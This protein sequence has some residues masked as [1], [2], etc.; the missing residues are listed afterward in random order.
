[1]RKLKPKN[2][3]LLHVYILVTLLTLFA[4]LVVTLLV[5][6]S[7][8]QQAVFD[9]INN[10]HSPAIY[11]SEK[12]SETLQKIA[13]SNHFFQHHN[14]SHPK[15]IFF[16]NSL[17]NP[18][19]SIKSYIKNI[20]DLKIKKQNINIDSTKSRLEKES[21]TLIQVLNELSLA[22]N[23]NLEL[24]PDL[25]KSVK[26]RAQQFSRLHIN[27]NKTLQQKL[28]KLPQE[29]ANKLFKLL[30][31][32]IAV[33]AL[34]IFPLILNIKKT[35]NRM[36][37]AEDHQRHLKDQADKEKSRITALLSA[38][39]IGILFEDNNNNVE[40]INPAFKRMWALSDEKTLIGHSLN[41]LLSNSPNLF[42]NL[43][44][45]S[46]Y[47]LQVLDTHEISERFEVN[48]N[49]GRVLAQLSYPVLDYEKGVIGRLWVYEDITH[50][51]QTAQQLLHLAEHDHLTGLFNRHRFQQDLSSLIDSCSRRNEK[52]A[53]LYFDLD[54]FKFINDTYGHGCGDNVLLRTSSEIN[55]VVRGAELF[56]RL[57][58]DE[59]A[60]LLKLDLVHNID[61]LP[62]RITKTVAS[63][64]FRFQGN[65]LRVTTSVGVAIYPDHGDNSEDLVA[66]ADTAMYQAK[67]M[68]KN[69]WSLYNPDRDN[70]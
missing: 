20:N 35:I 66:H 13:Q 31:V 4:A 8:E 28:A 2:A 36:Y 15:N 10:Y 33:I 25:I 22:Q 42:P 26:F 64:P 57:G 43:D 61:A 27:A 14:E 59:F 9:E 44:H 30:F 45:S 58:G 29:N 50:E 7:R 38:M 5:I 63:I 19:Y 70:S 39:N 55:T 3:I 49:D 16:S 60:V 65:N 12:L 54:E 40:Y 41:E 56:A 46:K 18:A 51:R 69:T 67:K 24:L 1:M 53:L 17:N 37:L 52:F 23:Q 34:I 6:N 62:D 68:G 32:T 11:Y 47:I 48:L 21:N